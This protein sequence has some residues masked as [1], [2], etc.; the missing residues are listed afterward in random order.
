MAKQIKI[1]DIARM[2]GVSAGTVDRILHNRGNVSAS[3]RAAVEKVL[4]EV[5]YK[6]NIHASAISRR[7]EYKIDIVIPTA[8]GGEY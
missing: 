4:A 5:D 8:L 1:K 2:A 7:K 3:S 6:Y